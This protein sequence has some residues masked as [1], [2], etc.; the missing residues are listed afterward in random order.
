MIYNIDVTSFF[1]RREPGE[2]VVVP[3]NNYIASGG[4]SLRQRAPTIARVECPKFMCLGWHCTAADCD[5]GLVCI[6]EPVTAYKCACGSIW[7]ETR[8]GQRF[9][10]PLECHGPQVLVDAYCGECNTVRQEQRNA[11]DL[12]VNRTPVDGRTELRVEFA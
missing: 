7:F 4:N 12:I 3:V 6:S 1:Y 8:D 9:K 11:V 10:P 2:V 5:F